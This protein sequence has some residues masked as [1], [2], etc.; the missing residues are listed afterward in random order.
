MV[1]RS[2]GSSDLMLC[3]DASAATAIIHCAVRELRD[4]RRTLMSTPSGTKGS[5]IESLLAVSVPVLSEQSTSQPASASMAVSFWQMASR[6]A[7]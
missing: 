1:T 5:W 7:R 4:N 3:D 6:R 2:I